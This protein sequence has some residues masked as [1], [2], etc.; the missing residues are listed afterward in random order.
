MRGHAAAMSRHGRGR[1]EVS[2]RN[3]AQLFNS[4]DPS[5]FLEKDLDH[6]VEEFLLGW[7]EEHPR[8]KPLELVLHLQELP[9]DSSTLRSIRHAVRN[10]FAYRTR[11]SKVQ[12]RQLFKQ[13]QVSLMIGLG[14]LASCLL[15][16]DYLP[17][18]GQ[19]AFI[20]I[21]QESLSIGGWV[22]MWRPLQIYL[23][24][25]WPILG[26]IRTHA[27]MSRMD[28]TLEQAQPRSGVA[29]RIPWP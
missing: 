27:R 1:I 10:Y 29:G 17:T 15:L 18:H 22:A 24:D 2:L 21:V 28:V 9:G 16:S 25:W 8:D 11:Q 20:G 13:G 3:A 26:R 4:L 23:Y 5:P 12:L 6:Q 7:A 14:F 19:G